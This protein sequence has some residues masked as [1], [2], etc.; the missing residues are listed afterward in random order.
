MTILLVW[1][2]A[3]NECVGFDEAG[4]AIWAATGEFPEGYEPLGTSSLAEAFR[5][6][7]AEDGEQLA[8][9]AAVADE[10]HQQMRQ[11]FMDAINFSIE[12]DEGL[13]FLRCWREGD[14]D[15]IER[16]WP[17]FT[18]DRAF[19]EGRQPESN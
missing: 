12:T 5:D 10:D 11:S 1:N 16:E 2:E 6:N 13:A 18:F 19:L 4:D 8:V 3:K 15:A 14:F 9:V 17:E 7:Y